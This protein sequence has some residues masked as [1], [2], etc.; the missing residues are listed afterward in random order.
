M[1]DGFPLLEEFQDEHT[2]ERQLES[3]LDDASHHLPDLDTGVLGDG[4]HV[5]S[6]VDG[7]DVLDQDI[8]DNPRTHASYSLPSPG[9][10]MLTHMP[11]HSY[12]QS[13]S[14]HSV[15]ASPAHYSVPPSPQV[16]PSPH[17]V[18]PSPHPMQS[19][20]SVPPSPAQHTFQAP[21][22]AQPPSPAIYSLPMKSPVK[23]GRAHV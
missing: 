1:E 13:S 11:S 5:P 21:S 3:L 10:P 20:A 23:I 9:G 19:P 17:Q 16:P 2:L 22:P 4:S 12:R 15:H 18:P 7:L 8:F 6:S 14:P